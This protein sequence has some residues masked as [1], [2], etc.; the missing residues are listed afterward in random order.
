M[1]K[2]LFG[3]AAVYAGA[4]MLAWASDWAR[5]PWPHPPPTRTPTAGR[6]MPRVAHAAGR[7]TA[8]LT[9]STT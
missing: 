5:W 1:K 9:A 6:L 8:A 4:P 2:T 7:T 3:A